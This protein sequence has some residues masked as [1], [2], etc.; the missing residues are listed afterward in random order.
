MHRRT[1]LASL[2]CLAATRPIDVIAHRGAHL[3]NPENSLPAIQ[4]AIGLGVDWVEIDVR[5]TADG[6]HILMH[7]AT[8]NRTTGSTGEIAQLTLQQLKSHRLANNT[9]IPTLDEA[10]DLMRTKCGVYFDA[11][12]ISATAII[13][14]LKRYNLMDRAVVYGNFQ[15]MKDLT[16]QGAAHLAMPEAVSIETTKRILQDLNPRVI[17]FDARDFQPHIIALAKQANKGIFVD[18]LGPADT[19]EKW[20]EAIHLGA[21]GIQTD[22]PAQ[23]IQTLNSQR[24]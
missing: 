18:R 3:D 19:R 20:L 6:H 2:S 14:S 23:L 8:V 24:P 9:P 4:A 17:A 22:H 7:D 15:L 5:T 21:T 11:K 13:A 1:F 12:R 16:D 10:L